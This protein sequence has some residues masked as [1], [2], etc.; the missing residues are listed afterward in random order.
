MFV[1]VLA[2]IAS[3]CASTPTVVPQPSAIAYSRTGGIAGFNDQ[4]T[5]DVNGKATLTRRTGKF[6][7]TLDDKT[8]KQIQT[9]FQTAGFATVPEDSLPARPV[10]DGF[11]YVVV[12]QGR[13]VRTGDT[14]IPEKLQPIL[15]MLNRIVD[16]GGK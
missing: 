9:A 6:D 7:F 4:L 13:T 11:T 5:I 2:L 3:A 10:P 14:A 12:Y 1:I 15:Q 16:S 8:L